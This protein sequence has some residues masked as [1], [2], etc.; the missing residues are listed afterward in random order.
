MKSSTSLS[1]CLMLLACSLAAWPADKRLPLAPQVMTAKTVYIDNHTGHQKVADQAYQELQKWG[2]FEV[3]LDYNRADLVLY[4]GYSGAL[5][6][7]LVIDPYSGAILWSG[8]RSSVHYA[9]VTVVPARP[10]HDLLS[11]FRKRVEEQSKK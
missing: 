9:V 6:K 3:V 10:I 5:S 8:L 4:F 11:D 7:L 2:R 1:A